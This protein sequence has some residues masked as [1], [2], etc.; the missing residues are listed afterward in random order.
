[1]RIALK[2]DVDT[3]R[4]T[5]EG[6]PALLRLFD[7]YR[8]SATFLWSLGPDHTGRALRRVFRRGFLSKVSRTSVVSHYGIKTLLYGVLL[9]GPMIGQRAVES[10]RSAVQAG[11]E[12]GIHCYD[13]V[14]W[15]DHVAR[16]D[17]T[18]TRRVLQQA[19]EI[20]DR[21]LGAPATHGSAGWQLNAHLLAVEEEWG[22]PYASDT[23]GTHPFLPVMA[24]RRFACPQLPTTLPTL[25]E[26]LGVDG[27]DPVTVHER[28]LAA[29]RVPRPHGHVYTLH[30]E[31][32]GMKLLP[33]ME[34]LLQVWQAEGVT[35]GT[36][37]GLHGALQGAVLPRHQVVWGSV[38]GRSGVLAL[39]GEVCE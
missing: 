12:S 4:G 10:L 14:A 20:H 27:V 18:W 34:K 28:V 39:Q 32:E 36:L 21:L 22:L 16:Q 29:S 13:H 37:A 26:L 3:L 15:Q 33:V 19:R 25:D 38:P 6:V 1:M 8:V 17:A 23:R 5:R 24:G 30:A 7:R 9:P 35:V 2:V 11:H 31:L